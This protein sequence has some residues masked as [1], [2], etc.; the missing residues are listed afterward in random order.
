MAV[1]YVVQKQMMLD[2]KSGDLVPRFD[3]S[4]AEQFGE[5]EF[6]LSPSHKPW[7]AAPAAA[8]LHLGLEHYTDEDYLLLVGNPILIGMATACASYW[9]DGRVNFLQWH[10]KDQRYIDVE[11]DID[12]TVRDAE[13]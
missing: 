1:V 6:L 8:S 9:N 12:A 13:D 10:G 7:P 4:A 3:L 5:L 11:A 2:R